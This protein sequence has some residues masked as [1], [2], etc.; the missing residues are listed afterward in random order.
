MNKILFDHQIDF[1]WLIPCQ[2][3]KNVIFYQSQN[4]ETV[5]RPSTQHNMSLLFFLKLQ[6]TAQEIFK[7]KCVRNNFSKNIFLI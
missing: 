2:N 6:Y 1:L 4:A 5:G 7:N 3:N